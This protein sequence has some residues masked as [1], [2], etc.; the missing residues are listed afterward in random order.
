MPCSNI[1]QFRNVRRTDCALIVSLQK[2]VPVADDEVLVEVRKTG[3]SSQPANVPRPIDF[4]MQESVALMSELPS[5]IVV[6]HEQSFSGTLYG[7]GTNWR[8]CCRE[9]DGK[10]SLLIPLTIISY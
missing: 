2:Y 7:R 1:G 10:G 4:I 9:T 8:F 5:C 6:L 3:M